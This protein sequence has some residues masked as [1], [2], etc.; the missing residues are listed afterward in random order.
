MFSDRCP[1]RIVQGIGQAC[2]QYV[3]CYWKWIPRLHMSLYSRIA[4][5]RSRVLLFTS[6]SRPEVWKWLNARGDIILTSRLS[7]PRVGRISKLYRSWWD[8]SWISKGTHCFRITS[9][10][11]KRGVESA[12]WELDKYW[13]YGKELRNEQR[14]DMVHKSYAYQAVANEWESCWR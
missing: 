2:C 13:V 12:Q 14:L 6:C 9:H 7:E 10:S 8:F 5:V 1:L 4:S 3:A 11:N